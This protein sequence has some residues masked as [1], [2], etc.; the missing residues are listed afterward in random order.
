MS[1]GIPGLHYR[2]EYRNSLALTDPWQLLQDI[3]ALSATSLRVVDPTPIQL[4]RFYR[5]VQVP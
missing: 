1:Q 3:P 2:L 4:R 5:A